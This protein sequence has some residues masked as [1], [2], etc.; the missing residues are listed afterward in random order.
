MAAVLVWKTQDK[1]L[2]MQIV[3]FAEKLQNTLGQDKCR[4]A[5]PLCVGRWSLVPFED[6]NYPISNLKFKKI[7]SINAPHM[8]R[9]TIIL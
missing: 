3:L 7:V 1:E 9:S 8:C 4:L 2:D 5:V 6:S